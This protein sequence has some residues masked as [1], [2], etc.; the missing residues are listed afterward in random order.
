MP[1]D[2]GWKFLAQWS[3]WCLLQSLFKMTFVGSF[4][5]YL[6]VKW[7][8]KEIKNYYFLYPADNF[9]DIF[10]LWPS[11]SSFLDARTSWGNSLCDPNLRKLFL[12]KTMPSQATAEWTTGGN[13]PLGSDLFL[14]FCCVEQLRI[15]ALDLRSL[16]ASRR[17]WSKGLNLKS[18]GFTNFLTVWIWES[19]FLS[20]SLFPHL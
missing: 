17:K 19:C 16:Q 11:S 2:S 7:L 3:H 12:N 5:I 8:M 18:D 6:S 20:L 1:S 4:A 9:P 14:P 13:S 15:P 10:L